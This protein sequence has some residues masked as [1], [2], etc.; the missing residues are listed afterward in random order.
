MSATDTTNRRHGWNL[1]TLMLKPLSRNR[2][3]KICNQIVGPGNQNPLL[4]SLNMNKICLNSSGF[5]L[6]NVFT[7]RGIYIRISYMFY[8]HIHTYY[9]HAINMYM[10][11]TLYK[12]WNTW[13]SI[14]QLIQL[15]SRFTAY[16]KAFHSNQILC[17][18]ELRRHTFL[19]KFYVCF[20]SAKY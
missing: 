10:E 20:V 14:Q 6:R 15:F 18:I 12:T 8:I 17:F 11:I 4:W 5:M 9:T 19:K 1:S 2:I 3:L 13:K 7:H 16:H